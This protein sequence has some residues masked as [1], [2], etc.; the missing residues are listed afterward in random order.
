MSKAVA[1]HGG[2]LVD[3]V[4]GGEARKEALDRAPSLRRVALNARTMSD[5]ELIA[6]GAYSPL[7][8]FMGEADYRTV[9]REMRLASGLPWTLPITLAVRRAAADAL[10][11]GD[12]VALVSPWEEPLGILRLE[13]RRLGPL[14]RYGRQEGKSSALVSRP[15]ALGS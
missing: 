12:E 10:R 3:R 11:D 6:I 8:G 7:E 5:L 2:K 1:P 14:R 15:P 4:R 9:L 13:E